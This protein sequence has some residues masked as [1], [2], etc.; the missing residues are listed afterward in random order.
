M[1]ENSTE[2]R[3][4]GVTEG[5]GVRTWEAGALLCAVWLLQASVFLLKM[6]CGK[7][8]VLVSSTKAN[9]ESGG[10]SL[11]RW[12]LRG[13]RP[14]C[15]YFSKCRP[16]WQPSRLLLLHKLHSQ[17]G[18]QVLSGW[19]N[20]NFARVNVGFKSMRCSSAD[21]SPGSTA[22]VCHCRPSPGWFWA[23][24][25][26]FLW[27]SRDAFN[28]QGMK[29][30]QIR[31]HAHPLCFILGWWRGSCSWP[32]WFFQAFTTSFLG[33]RND[34]VCK[35]LPRWRARRRGCSSVCFASQWLLGF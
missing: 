1:G 35:S 19:A 14:V 3:Q 2:I 4:C 34:K 25:L 12:H 26:M 24:S 9:C 8:Y 11:A 13:S 16:V 18:W 10:S 7:I 32:G 27:F 21:G 23:E 20:P 5:H 31:V 28:L 29:L 30:L 33:V 17:K 15:R 6:V 22:R